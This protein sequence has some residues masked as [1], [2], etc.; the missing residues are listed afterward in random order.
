MTLNGV[1][2]AVQM[3]VLADVVA[4]KDALGVWILEGRMDPGR[5]GSKVIGSMGEMFYLLITGIYKGVI[6]TH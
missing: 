6:F 2:L 4:G 3:E 1:S 5:V